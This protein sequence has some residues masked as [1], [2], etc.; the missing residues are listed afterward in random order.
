MPLDRRRMVVTGA[1]VC[2]LAAVAGPALARTTSAPRLGAVD[3]VPRATS[4]VGPVQLDVASPSPTL[5]GTTERQ[6][7][8]NGGGQANSGSG[9]ASS[10]LGSPRPDQ[11]ISADGRWVAFVSAATNL[12]PG[13]AHPPGGLYLRDRQNGTT[14]AIPWTN[15][16]PFPANTTAAEPAISADGSV[17]AFTAVIHVTLSG[18]IV[19]IN[20]TTPYVLVWDRQSNMTQ[21]VSIDSTGKP[22]AG[23]QPSISADGRFVGYT[24]WAP[25]DTTPPVL[26][27]LMASPNDIGGCTGMT[28]TISV[29]ATDPDDAVSSVNLSFWPSGEATTTEPMVAKGGNLWQALI[30]VQN[31][32]TYNSQINY[33]VRATDSHGNTSA[34]YPATPSTLVWDVCIQ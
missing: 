8:T 34:A 10:T 19:A 17:V 20:T 24:Q 1:L 16:G 15:G 3:Q 7:V 6:S 27:N 33:S 30:S 21:I 5:P 13:P 2:A 11:A 18:G 26:S 22:T 4:P 9:G 14:T 29:T 25:P 12:V 23:W 32:W 28:S 31:S